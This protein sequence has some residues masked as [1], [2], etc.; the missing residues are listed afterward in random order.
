MGET[1]IALPQT[2]QEWSKIEEVSKASPTWGKLT[3]LYLKQNKNGVRLRKYRKHLQHGGT[4]IA[5]PQTEQEWSKIEEV[6]K[7]SPTWGK[8]T[9]LYLKQNKNGVRLRKYRKHL[10]HGGTYIALPQTE[11]EWSKIEEVSKAS[12][13][14]GNLH[15][16]T[17]NRTRME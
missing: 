16:F 11:Q 3:S 13:T 15:R 1:Y 17:S 8:L 12:P 5:L 6:S 2:E 9:S 10:Q 4:Y 14:W 7:A